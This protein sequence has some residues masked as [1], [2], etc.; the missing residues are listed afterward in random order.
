[1]TTKSS[2]MYSIV[3]VS[4]V[5][6]GEGMA[7]EWDVYKGDCGPD[8]DTSDDEW[9]TTQDT[10]GFCKEWIKEHETFLINTLIPQ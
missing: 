6:T 4:V 7:N 9:H 2:N 8:Q 5:S 1:M 3:N 10:L